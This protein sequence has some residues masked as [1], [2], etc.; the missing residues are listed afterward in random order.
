MAQWVEQQNGYASKT[1][2]VCKEDCHSEATKLFSSTDVNI[3][4]AERPY[5]GAAIGSV[6]YI[7]GF[8]S[9]KVVVWS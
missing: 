9:E 6:T 7:E 8:V 1:W 2:L 5:L 3:T 4:T